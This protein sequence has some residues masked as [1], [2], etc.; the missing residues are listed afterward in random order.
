MAQVPIAAAT[1]EPN[2]TRPMESMG[3]KTEFS[4]GKIREERNREGKTFAEVMEKTG[5]D[6]PSS[7]TAVG[8]KILKLHHKGLKS[9]LNDFKLSSESGKKTRNTRLL[10]TRDTGISALQ[11]NTLKPDDTELQLLQTELSSLPKRDPSAQIV[12][13]AQG[14]VKT[15]AAAAGNAE[16]RPVSS[17]NAEKSGKSGSAD[18]KKNNTSLSGT[19]PRIEIVD[20]RNKIT[21]INVSAES[22]EQDSSRKPSHRDIQSRRSVR[23][24]STGTQ[25]TDSTSVKSDAGFAVAETD[26]ELNTKSEVKMTERSAAAELARKLDS[27]AGNDI[28]RQVKVVLNRANT[29]EVRINLRPDNLGRVSVRINLDDN[30]LTGRIFVE[31]AAAREAFR[32]ALDGLQTKLVESGFGAADLEL[33]WDDSGKE[34]TQG[35][36]HSGK[37]QRNLDDALHEFENIVPTTVY[38]EAVDSHVNMVV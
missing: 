12:H 35:G 10:K 33:A 17:E 5:K 29:G 13:L 20:N 3:G 25:N 2:N 34:F 32:S 23:L 4:R 8:K 16:L 27:Q 9:Q 24:E 6:L 37:Q 38:G 26:I 21:A 18:S 7:E 36:Q 14:S 1:I 15:A 30:R 31:T 28:V 19:A 22:G 11:A